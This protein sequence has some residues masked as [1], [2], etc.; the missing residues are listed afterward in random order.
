MYYR[1]KGERLKKKKEKKKKKMICIGRCVLRDSTTC[2]SHEIPFIHLFSFSSWIFRFP[3]TYGQSTTQERPV[4]PP[5]SP[6]LTFAIRSSRI[7][8]PNIPPLHWTKMIMMK[9]YHCA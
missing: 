6:S 5:T 1:A 4:V 9:S 8:P 2:Y 7:H 3:S